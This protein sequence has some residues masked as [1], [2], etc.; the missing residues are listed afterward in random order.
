MTS[1]EY[2]LTKYQIAIKLVKIGRIY[3]HVIDCVINMCCPYLDIIRYELVAAHYN[4]LALY[5]KP[6]TTTKP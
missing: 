2:S 5:Y 1:F 3:R 6:A 4:S